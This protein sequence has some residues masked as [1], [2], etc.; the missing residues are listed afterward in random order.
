MLVTSF[1]TYP[2]IYKYP[3]NYIPEKITLE[4]YLSIFSTSHLQRYMLNSV[5]VSTGAVIFTLLISLLPAYAFSRFDF[6][7]KNI[8]LPSIIVCMMLPQLVLVVPFLRILM[9]LKLINTHTGLILVY[10]TLTTA[11][12]IWFLVSFFEKIPKELEEAAMIDGCG[13]LRTLINIVLP[14]MRP[15]ISAVAIYAFFLSWNEFMFAL[16]YLSSSNA[17]TLPVFLGRFVGQYQTRWGELFAGSVISYLVPLI[18]FALLQK[19][20]ITALVKGAIKE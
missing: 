10:L 15:G 9:S 8:L 19:Q 14:I 16:S 5:I 13:R 18:A 7:Y 11:V 4:H 2:E 6:P 20:F 17:L 3:I 12:A 1:K